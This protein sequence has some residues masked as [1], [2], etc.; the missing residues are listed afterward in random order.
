M[1]AECALLDFGELS[2]FE[3]LIKHLQTAHFWSALAIRALQAYRERL[4][5]HPHHIGYFCAHPNCHEKLNDH[6]G[7]MTQ[8][9]LIAHY[10]SQH[11]EH[12]FRSYHF[13]ALARSH[14]WQETSKAMTLSQYDTEDIQEA[15]DGLLVESLVHI[16]SKRQLLSRLD[17]P[18]AYAAYIPFAQISA[19][20]QE[21]S[22]I[23]QTKLTSQYLQTFAAIV[24]TASDIS[25]QINQPHA[26]YI[27]TDNYVWLYQKHDHILKIRSVA[28]VPAEI[29]SGMYSFGTAISRGIGP[30]NTLAMLFMDTI[31]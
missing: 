28:H 5:Q 31:E 4:S 2:N 13:L 20:V 6:T 16:S 1:E 23:S 14:K 25:D 29:S 21:G 15:V 27:Y 26:F 9:D 30:Q 18:H 8:Q 24:T 7:D 3:V 22:S 12:N 11:S 10:E 19:L 17:G